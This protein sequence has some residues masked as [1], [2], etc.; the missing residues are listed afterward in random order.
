MRKFFQRVKD[1]VVSIAVW[2]GLVP[3]DVDAWL[4]QGES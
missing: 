2:L 3:E 1:C 4:K